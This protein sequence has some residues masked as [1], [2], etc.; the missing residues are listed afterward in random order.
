MEWRHGGWR[1]GE[2]RLWRAV[3]S[4][5]DRGRGNQGAR[6]AMWLVV[7]RC[8]G[9]KEFPGKERRKK[10]KKL[11]TA[12]GREPEATGWTAPREQGRWGSRGWKWSW[13]GAIYWQE[14][15]EGR[16]VSVESPKES[17]DK[18]AMG[19]DFGI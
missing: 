3:V 11:G 5:L 15:R 12:R 4:D 7:K 17:G 16:V 2:Q 6:M 14:I 10:Q 8:D 9:K 13:R 19:T 18:S 1:G